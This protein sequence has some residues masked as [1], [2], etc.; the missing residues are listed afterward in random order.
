MAKRGGSLMTRFT[1]RT[2]FCLVTAVAIG[3]GVW[4]QDEWRQ[5]RLLNQARRALQSDQINYSEKV[6]GKGEYRLSLDGR[7]LTPK[8]AQ[9]LAAAKSIKYLTLGGLPSNEV[10]VELSQGFHFVYRGG[11]QTRSADLYR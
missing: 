6:N 7:N 9:A 2:M 11:I 4:N 8:S 1:L 10:I 3:L 5:E